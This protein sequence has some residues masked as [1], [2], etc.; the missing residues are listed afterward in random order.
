MVETL[1]LSEVLKHAE[2]MYE[3]VMIVAKRARQI[4][5]EQR[6]QTQHNL[7]IQTEIRPGGETDFFE[8]E[9]LTPSEPYEDY[10]RLPKPSVVAMKEMLEGK[11]RYRYIDEGTEEEEL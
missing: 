1:D 3:A 11:I 7:M 4:N 2:S 9:D 8:E 5:D 10:L 6:A